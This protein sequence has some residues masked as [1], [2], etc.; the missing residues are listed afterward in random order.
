MGD[1]PKY[2]VTPA[3]LFL[4]LGLDY[5]YPFTLKEKKFRNKNMIKSYVPV[6]VCFVT[7][8]V[9]LELV[10]DLTTENCL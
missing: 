3:G 4:N 7:K 9:H 8:A 6:F 10:T 2:R 5:C 1:L